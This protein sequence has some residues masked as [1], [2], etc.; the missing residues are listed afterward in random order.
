MTRVLH[1]FSR[2]PVLQGVWTPRIH[3]LS[4]TSHH[5]R[6][7]GEFSTEKYCSFSP[8][9]HSFRQRPPQKD[10]QSSHHTG[11]NSLRTHLTLSVSPGTGADWPG[12]ST[13]PGP[14]P[15]APLLLFMMNYRPSYKNGVKR[16]SGYVRDVS[17][18][19]ETHREVLTDEMQR[20]P[21]L[22]ERVGRD[23]LGQASW[24]P[25]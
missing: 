3:R 6:S 14:P 17:F 11:G 21:G 20:G 8:W 22:C 19:L 18:S 4:I 5:V 25:P 1:R 7:F 23:A 16:S 10:R 2:K 13:P 24:C 15:H 9:K 12:S